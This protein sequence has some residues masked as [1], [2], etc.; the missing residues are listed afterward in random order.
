MSPIVAPHPQLAVWIGVAVLVAW[1]LYKRIR[2]L[3]GRQQLSP[4]RPWFTVVVFPLLFAALFAGSLPHPGGSL[5]L[6]GGAAIGVGLGL[7]GLR[8]TRFEATPAGL[9]YTPSAHLGIA[10]SLLVILRLGYR[11]V[12]A[13]LIGA[14]FDPGQPAEFVR[15]PLTLLIFGT[16]AGYYVAYAIGLLRWRSRNETATPPAAG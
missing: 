8:L 3:I 9:Y 5:A 15:S 10:L 11:A 13:A 1:R 2:R 7:Y 14:Q 6:A 12:H 16:L 4:F